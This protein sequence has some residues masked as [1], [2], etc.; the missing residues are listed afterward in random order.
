MLDIL[1]LGTGASVPSK[2]RSLPGVAV[3]SGSEIVLF[4][5]GEGT[6]RQ[7]MFSRM[8]FMKVSTIFISHMHGDHTLGL[9]GL[10]Q[11][12]GMSGRQDDLVVLGPKGIGQR[13]RDMI[14]ATEGEIPYDLN[15]MELE[16][17]NVYDLGNI[18][19]ECFA[20]DHEVESYGFILRENDRPGKLDKEKALK[21]GLTEGPDLA[22]ICEGEAVKGVRPEDVLGENKKGLSVVYTGDTRKC[23]QLPKIAKDCD[24]II[25]EATYMESESEL[26][27]ERFHCTAKTAAET[28]K[29]CSARYLFLIHISNRYKNIDDVVNEAKSIFPETYAPND[30][31]MFSITDRNIRSA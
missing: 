2:D 15:F 4:D 12:M 6:Q 16:N 21:L 7:F 20:T 26:A 28:A 18:S 31:Q 14:S 22:R 23:P 25:H 13:V 1:F 10:I 8:S 19:V 27:V 24:A 9:P 5:C 3:R 30:L 17:G 29:E 11:T